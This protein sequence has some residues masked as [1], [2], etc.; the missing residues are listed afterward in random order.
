MRLNFQRP[1]GSGS[2]RVTSAMRVQR[3][4]N[5]CGKL[6]FRK[7]RGELIFTIALSCFYYLL[8]I[9]A[10]SC[11]QTQL[12]IILVLPPRLMPYAQH[13]VAH[14]ALMR[15]KQQSAICWE[16]EGKEERVQTPRKICFSPC[17]VLQSSLGGGRPRLRPRP[18]P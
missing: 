2:A 13:S 1:N 7:M 16:E 3:V 10:H 8:S 12:A 11:A 18:R 9:L 15:Q 14:N 5:M 4:R 6:S 17:A